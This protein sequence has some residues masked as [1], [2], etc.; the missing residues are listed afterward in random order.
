M[1]KIEIKQ[2]DC[3]ELMKD[4]PDNSIDI[5]FTSPPYNRKRNDKYKFYNDTIDDY[6]SFLKSFTDELLRV[7][8]GN[9]FVNIQKNYYNKSEIFSYLG[10]YSDK[11]CEVII[12]EKT[13]P[14]P[15]SGFNITNSYEMFIVFGKSLKSNTTY[16]KNIIS[17][18]VNS[19]MP[20]EHKAVMKQEVSDWFIEKFT[21][22]G[23]VVLDCFM[24]LGTTAI[25]CQKFNRDFIG[26]EIDKNYFSIAKERLGLEDWGDDL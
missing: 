15:A 11:I 21:K 3:L 7:T 25:S 13:N 24:G 8:K 9:V 10:Y 6:L 20:K 2:G 12:W 1:S 16:T 14:M 17:S 23:D 4:I 19:N 18:S 5:S 22:E 26:I